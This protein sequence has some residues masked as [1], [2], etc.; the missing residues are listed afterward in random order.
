MNIEAE[1]Q[2]PKKMGRPSEFSDDIFAIICERMAEGETLRQLC[3]DPDMPNRNTVL[4]WVK[5]DD[6]RRRQYDLA[7]QAQAD[8][9]ADEIISIAYDTSNDTIKGKDGQPLCNH[10]WIARSRLKSDNLKFLMAKLHPGRYGE[11]TQL[12]L[13]AVEPVMQ[14]SWEREIISPI[15]DDNGNIISAIDGKALRNRIR[16][17]EERLGIRSDDGP[18]KQITYD[19]GPLPSRI[20]GEIVLKLV[21]VIK[22]NVPRA[23]QRS[24]EEVLDEVLSECAK[25]LKAKYSTQPAT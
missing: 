19:P 24:P 10:E 20:E 21:D 25:A 14:I 12:E 17:L 16:E 15:H 2:E 23:D 8:W 11:K 1:V 13:P 7:R 4:R 18:P 3:S 6:G 9:Y 22:Q 5:N